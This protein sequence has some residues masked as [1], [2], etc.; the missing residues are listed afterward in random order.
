MWESTTKYH[1]PSGEK[2]VY[3]MTF[4]CIHP[5]HDGWIEIKAM[6]EHDAREYC[7]SIQ[8]PKWAFLYTQEE[9]RPN[10]FP[11]GCLAQVEV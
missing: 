11:K 3:C 4:A 5:L 7:H 6:T 8:G 2:Q 9:F 10:M 1:P